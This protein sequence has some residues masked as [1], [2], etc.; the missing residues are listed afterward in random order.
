MLRIGIVGSDNSHALAFAKLAN[1]EKVFG[2]TVRV[3]TICGV[4]AERTQEVATGGN[5]PSIVGSPEEML[6]NIDAAMVVHRH[7]DLHAAN[8][9]PFLK[10]GMP[11]FVD[12]PIAIKLDDAKAILAAAKASGSL[13]TSFSS[14]RYGPDTVALAEEA[15]AAGELR[16]GTITGPCDFGSEYGGPFFYGTHATEI[17]IRL[18]GEDV[19]SV[20][21]V[22]YGD[23]KIA[24]LKFANGAVATLNLVNK[25]HYVFHGL[26]IG[27]NGYAAREISAHGAY[28]EVMRLFLE[29]IRTGKRP[30]TDEQML[31]PIRIVH[32][33]ARSVEAGG[34]EVALNSVQ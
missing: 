4:Q 22:G 3:V 2:D 31:R 32:A 33:I 7:G 34:A 8:A 25:A 13:V 11:V 29:M 28:Q 5:I 17:C 14:L 19:T 18:F 15:A 30:L 1:V 21:A 20:S 6:G 24:T 16:L 27:K 12:K 10:K 9:L 26:V 23:N